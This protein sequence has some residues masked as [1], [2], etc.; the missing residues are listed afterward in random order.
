MANTR[1]ALGRIP[2]WFDQG[3]LE[4]KVGTR[5]FAMGFRMEAISEGDLEFPHFKDCYQSGLV[6]DEVRRR[7]LFC[8]VGVDLSSPQ[9]PG[10]AIVTVAL[11]P[12][13]QVRY[14]VD[15]RYG[16]WKSPET[17]AEITK[18]DLEYPVD[19]ITV[20]NNAYQQSMIDWPSA[21]KASFP[22]WTKVEAHTTGKNK[23]DP[24]YGLPGLGIEFKNKAWA[25]ASSQWEGHP[26]TCACAW[27]EWSR[28]V[29]M[30]PRGHQTDFVM[31]TWFALSGITRFGRRPGGG[32]RAPRGINNR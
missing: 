4:K 17:A 24:Q 7:R 14:P 32:P 21:N 31:A 23:A 20:E 22:W 30:Y 8:Y 27:C 25:V 11:D 3:T 28:Q 19:I 1:Q 6:L 10:N 13:T 15:V 16:S 9:R 18:V 12:V 5:E 2:S 29:S 26:S